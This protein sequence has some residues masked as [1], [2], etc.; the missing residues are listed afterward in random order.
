MFMIWI[1][2]LWQKHITH[3]TQSRLQCWAVYALTTQSYIH[4][5]VYI[6]HYMSQSRTA[7]PASGS[8]TVPGVSRP[9]DLW[10]GA[11]WPVLHQER[12]QEWVCGSGVTPACRTHHITSH[13]RTDIYIP[14]TSVC[15]SYTLQLSPNRKAVGQQWISLG[16]HCCREPPYWSQSALQHHDEGLYT[17]TT[18]VVERSRDCILLRVRRG[19][20][21]VQLHLTDVDPHTLFKTLVDNLLETRKYLCF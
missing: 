8:V 11:L 20:A 13:A 4:H 18:E 12:E 17:N 1:I 10:P 3:A 15:I 6:N 2:D 21:R 9:L 7:E 5:L 14:Y 16:N 19:E